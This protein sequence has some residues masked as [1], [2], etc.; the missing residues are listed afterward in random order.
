MVLNGDGFEK[1]EISEV[2]ERLHSLRA[3]QRMCLFEIDEEMF[4]QRYIP[5][6]KANTKGKMRVTLLWLIPLTA[7]AASII[8]YFLY[9]IFISNNPLGILVCV[10]TLL[11]MIPVCLIGWVREIGLIRFYY[12]GKKTVYYDLEKMRSEYRVE[13]LE[14]EIADINAQIEP[15]EIRC[16]QL[17][18]EQKKIEQEEKEKQTAEEQFT[19]ELP[20]GK[21][22]LLRENRLDDIQI[23]EIV[24]SYDRDMQKV[25]ENISKEEEKIQQYEKNIVE[26]EEKFS[27]SKKRTLE[28]ILII[29]IIALL[30]FI[31]DR[32]MQTFLTIMA[33]IPT[34]IVLFF[35]YKEFRDTAFDYYFEHDPMMFK[36]YAFRNSMTTN[37]QKISEAKKEIRWMQKEIVWLEEQKNEMIKLGAEEGSR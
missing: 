34:F 33:V 5:Q 15:L 24:N 14:R 7:V 22:F 35:Y 20:V 9:C 13:E 32:S 12:V 30:Q 11:F 18:E 26:I 16:V 27:D 8:Y 36:D 6:R 19:G 21:R 3:R 1:S 31:P 37:G 4:H 28:G 2:T 25:R 29:G 23:T 10:L 17:K